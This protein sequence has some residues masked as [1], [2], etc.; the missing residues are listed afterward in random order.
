MTMRHEVR[1][2]G[3]TV[4]TVSGG[5]LVAKNVGADTVEFSFSE[6]WRGLRKSV[7]FDGPGA[8]VALRADSGGVIVPWEAIDGPGALRVSFVGRDGGGK[9][10]ATAAM[11]RPWV[12]AKNGTIDGESPTD[13]TPSELRQAADEALEAADAA[14]AA[15]DE[16]LRRAESGEFDGPQGAQG[17]QGVQGPQGEQGPAGP[18]GPQGEPGQ[19]FR[20]AKTFPSVDSMQSGHASDGLPVGSFAIID[21]GD[22]QD[23]DNATLWAKGEAAYVYIADLS[24]MAGIKGDSGPQGDP[25]PQG[26]KGD[27]FAG[28]TASVDGSTGTPAVD[29]D[30]RG[31]GQAKTAHFAFRGLKGERGVKG[32]P[33]VSPK[34]KVEQTSDGA[35]VTVAD[36]TGTT[37]ARLSNG[38]DGK[39]GVAP[40]SGPG[41]AVAEDGTVSADIGGVRDLLTL[42]NTMVGTPVDGVSSGAMYYTVSPLA[43]IAV[44]HGKGVHID[45][46]SGYV[47]FM[48]LPLGF[49]LSRPIARTVAAVA[50]DA[51][52]VDRYIAY[53]ASGSDVWL[54]A[55][56]DGACDFAPSSF[57]HLVLPLCGGGSVVANL[58]RRTAD[59]TDKGVTFAVRPDGGIRAVGTQSADFPRSYAAR[60]GAAECG[61]VPGRVYTLS[62]AGASADMYAAVQIYLAEGGS[63]THAS[64]GRPFVFT[65][66]D[67]AASYM[68]FA[69]GDKTRDPAQAVDTTL[70]PMLCEGIE[71]DYVPYDLGASLG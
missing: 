64:R 5:E 25:G 19:P 9:V 60:A 4:D 13:P 45:S 47:R 6:E 37:T 29:V 30:I 31:E 36:A 56:V 39:D 41:I 69:S 49:S 26:P 27:G 18:A 48:R 62:C 3:R 1:V 24:G 28:A 43:V 70:Y 20:V 55:Q 67:G 44:G 8:T 57:A 63:V 16:I 61:I 2:D 7:V 17:V 66:P 34:A 65:A 35:T 59:T 40:K 21:T 15:A 52:G 11:A 71:A 22:V 68:C 58:W 10:V 12:V 46:G 50:K 14:A 53:S 33:G 38:R 42:G 23:P 51:K 32:D 54:E